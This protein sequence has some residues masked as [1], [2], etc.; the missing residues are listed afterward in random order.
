[1][2]NH[3]KTGRVYLVGAG[4]GDPDLITRRGYFLLQQCDAVVYDNLV[5]RELIA[6]LPPRV[7]RFYVGK[8]AGKHTLSQDRINELLVQLARQGKQV[9]RLKGGD[10]F[11]FGR[12]GEEALYLVGHG[13]R[14]FVV[15]GVTA[16]IAG[17]AY[18]GIPVTHRGKAGHVIFVTGHEAASPDAS[19]VPWSGLAGLAEGTLVGYMGVGQLPAIVKKLIAGG[20]SPQT[21]AAVVERTTFGTQ[22]TITAPLA[23]LTAR[24]AAAGITPPALFVIGEV[25]SLREELDWFGTLPL[26][27]K[28][29]MITLPDG[30][31]TD[32]GRILRDLGAEVL[33]L[34]VLS[35]M[36]ECDRRAWVRLQARIRPGDWLHF[37]EQ[38]GVDYFLEIWR[39]QGKDIRALAV[40]SIA[41]TGIGALNAL[42]T[43]GINP[44]LVAA[45]S[46]TAVG[47]AEEMAA[48]LELPGRRV[49][50]VRGNTGDTD[51]DA[52]LISA[53]AE[54]IPMIVYRNIT[55]KWDEDDLA[56]F[57]RRPPDIV[58][59]TSEAAVAALVSIL[60]S[61]GVKRHFANAVC[62]SIEPSTTK[63]ARARGITIT[64][65]STV[66]SVEGM[67]EAL[68]ASQINTSK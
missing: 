67:V 36:P 42:K 52:L 64:I 59:L 49:V 47:L 4:P 8:K 57:E 68:L 34:R 3:E 21:P 32:L 46:T 45:R 5:P 14:F 18:A 51:G 44:D 25:V 15:P 2:S 12:G 50:M 13:I 35:F 33:S 37:T 9:V 55:A 29:V 63:A 6:A 26:F 23:E 41:A 30:H 54:V 20:K 39:R 31:S 61:A 66:P 11:V 53:G 17:P 58:F 7:E 40:F 62:I 28:R 38:N 10:P 24:A 48:Q 27:G 16:G 19:D 56:R 43:A 60:E 65:E 22:C 1:M